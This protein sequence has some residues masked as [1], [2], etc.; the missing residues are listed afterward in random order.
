METKVD[1]SLLFLIYLCIVIKEFNNIYSNILG[2]TIHKFK[3]EITN[4]E[5]KYL[6]HR[7]FKIRD[8]QEEQ[9][10]K[11]KVDNIKINQS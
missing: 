3:K 4:E 6:K 2:N 5:L 11:E 10:A 1:F 9:E 8:L 7:R